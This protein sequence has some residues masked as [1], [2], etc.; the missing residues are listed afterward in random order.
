MS[1]ST[2]TSAAVMDRPAQAKVDTPSVLLFG[3]TGRTG[4]RVLQQLLARA[5]A[6]RAVVRSADRLPDV[7]AADPL[8]EVVEA[9]VA[10]LSEEEFAELVSG[11]DAVISCLGHNISLVGVFG[12][13]RDLVTRATRGVVAAARRNGPERPV[14]FILM[15]SVSVNQPERADRRRGSLERGVVAFL[16][17]VIPPSK[18]NQDAADILCESV[19]RDDPCLQ[20][21]AVRPDSLL[22]GPVSGYVVHHELVSSLA[23]PDHTAMANVA[24][25]MCELATDDAL[26]ERWR[27]RLPVIVDTEA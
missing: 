26:W 27:S 8:L 4:G 5:V 24:H 11:R 10:T 6:V 17:V 13:P 12:P 21:V 25:F 14:R 22:E 18:D 1:E 3:A 7:A 19:G 23:R 20:W 15:S 2:T 9:D 16:R